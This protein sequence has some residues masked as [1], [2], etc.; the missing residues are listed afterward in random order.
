V[1]QA[2]FGDGRGVATE[3]GDVGHREAA[4]V[5]SP[6]EAPGVVGADAELVEPGGEGGGGGAEQI[7]GHEG[8]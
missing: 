2:V 1:H 8:S 4:A 3:V 5:Q 7:E 6:E